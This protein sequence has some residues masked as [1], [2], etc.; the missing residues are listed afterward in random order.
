MKTLLQITAA[1]LLL[2]LTAGC[3]GGSDETSS[4]QPVQE[5]PVLSVP[6]TIQ[7]PSGDGLAAF[8]ESGHE[9]VLLYCWIPMGEYEE[10]LPDLHFLNTLADR[11]ITAVPVQ[12]STE[13]R[14]AAQS[15]LNTLGIPLGVALGS[16]SLRAFLNTEM[17][18]SA[19]LVLNTGEVF[20]E[21]GF[22]AA[23]RAVR[24]GS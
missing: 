5:I 13:V 18:P 9:A 15:Q 8:D 20:R 24:S 23:E 6:G 16:D 12:F 4:E 7:I 11:G 14:N 10:S 2:A 22:G 17:L 19:A 21:S 3:T 1:S